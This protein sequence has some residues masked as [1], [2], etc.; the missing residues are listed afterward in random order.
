MGRLCQ[1]TL[2]S[3]S[4]TSARDFKLAIWHEQVKARKSIRFNSHIWPSL[5]VTP[6]ATLKSGEKKASAMVVHVYPLKYPEP[7][8]WLT[9]DDPLFVHLPGY[10][11][12]RWHWGNHIFLLKST[13]YSDPQLWFVFS[14][15]DWVPP[16][17]LSDVFLPLYRLSHTENVY[18]NVMSQRILCIWI[19]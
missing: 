12:K 8:R 17:G 15:F 2:L 9:V 19:T 18:R 10:L 1:T 5:T 14:G 11:R 3:G 13:G 4:F 6:S 16:W 7:A